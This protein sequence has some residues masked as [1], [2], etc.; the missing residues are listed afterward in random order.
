MKQY[1]KPN[2]YPSFST[3]KLPRY[4]IRIFIRNGIESG[5]DLIARY[6]R[7]PAGIFNFR[8]I[9]K[10]TRELITNELGSKIREEKKCRVCGCDDLHACKGGCFWIEPDL[11]SQCYEK[12]NSF[13][14]TLCDVKIINGQSYEETSERKVIAEELESFDKAEG[15]IY[16]YIDGKGGYEYRDDDDLEIDK[17]YLMAEASSEAKY[18]EAVYF[19]EKVQS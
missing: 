4:A 13:S 7:D 3:I 5:E 6:K 10:E 12:M 8:G 17:T 14:V 9:G 11:C 2:D 16:G 15:F 1:Q 19:F 18:D